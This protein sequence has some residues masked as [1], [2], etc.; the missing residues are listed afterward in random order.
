MT[1][2]PPVP[3]LSMH[4]WVTNTA[5][6]IDFLLAHWVES[7]AEQDTIYGTSVS[8]LQEIVQKFNDDPY[9]MASEI[10]SK[11]S[12][13][14]AR[15]YPD[16]VTIE[17]QVSPAKDQV[18]VTEFRVNLG[19]TIFFKVGDKEYKAPHQLSLIDSKFNSFIRINNG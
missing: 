3:T 5:E 12:T 9:R 10:Q 17:T 2:N 7:D 11:L 15:Y 1:N 13:Y 14:L 16:G 8:N 19:V 18:Q 4:G 6:K